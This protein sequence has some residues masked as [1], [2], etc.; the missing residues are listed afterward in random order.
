M[1]RK[2]IAGL[3]LAL[4]S[5]GAAAQLSGQQLTTVHTGLCADPTAAAF[6]AAGNAAGLRDYANAPTAPAW[7]AWRSTTSADD[8]LDAV[9]WANLTPIDTPD[10][11]ATYTNRALVAQAKQLN[12]Q[13]ILQGRSTIATGKL[14]VRQGLQ[15]AL[16]NV[17]TGV[18]G[19]LLDA[20]W[21]GANRVKAVI[22]RPVTRAER[23]FATGT[24]TTAVPGVLGWEGQLTEVDGARLVFN[25]NGSIW[26]C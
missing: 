4:L 25:D 19:A 21:A 13:I 18:G 6:I 3:A 26:G 1:I 14:N 16:L 8:L 17:P 12:L 11:T 23:I 24:G 5:L 20:G 10:N 9:V 22:N 7:Y 15:D 2:S